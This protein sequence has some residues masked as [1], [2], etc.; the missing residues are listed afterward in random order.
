MKQNIIILLL[1]L[2]VV[3]LT[4][5]VT[6]NHSKTTEGISRQLYKLKQEQTEV[7]N[8]LNILFENDSALN[9][10]ITY[11][12]NVLNE[13]IDLRVKELIDN[14]LILTKELMSLSDIQEEQAQKLLQVEEEYSATGGLGVLTGELFLSQENEENI[15]EVIKEDEPVEQ[16]II[17]EEAILYSCPKP[18]WSVDFGKFVNKISFNRT[19]RFSVTYDIKEG[20]LTNIVFSKNVSSKLN[21]AVV[22]F[23]N[24]AI[25]KENNVTTCSIP[26]AIEV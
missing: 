10:T 16:P 18:D 26:F 6:I 24:A 14:D 15:I 13:K 22:K 5:Y 11:Q 19:T 25:S 3:M 23:L 9:N 1:I 4:S 8:K 2:S 21:K 12:E 7:S 17:I 20:A